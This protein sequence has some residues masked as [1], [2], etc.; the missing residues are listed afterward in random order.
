MNS[1][2][3]A[4]TPTV[5]PDH[6]PR[7][8]AAIAGRARSAGRARRPSRPRSSRRR[9]PAPGASSDSGLVVAVHLDA[10]RRH[11]G[12]EGDGELPARTHVEVEALLGDDP[13]H[14]LGAERLRRRRA[15]RRRRTPSRELPA[16]GPEVGLVED[17]G[18]G[19]E[20]VRRACAT[21]TPPTSSAP[22]S[23]RTTVRGH[24]CGSSALTSSGV[25]SQPGPRV[26][27]SPCSAPASCARMVL[28]SF[29][30]PRRRAAPV[31]WR[32]R[33]G[34]PRPATAAPGSG[35]SAGSSPN[36]STRQES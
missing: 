18:R 31:R 29:R 6:H 11:A 3:C 16:A 32:A 14:R 27:M 30:A 13:H 9:R 25:R 20:L 10:L 28:T 17:V 12:G 5:D 36:G 1:W 19:A 8:D 23:A 34:R 24:S 26:P 15:R 2:V 7:P 33:S 35:R 4:S 21:S 22:P